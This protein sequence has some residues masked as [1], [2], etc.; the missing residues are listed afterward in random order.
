M[1][2]L[3]LLLFL[4]VVVVVVVDV[5]VKHIPLVKQ[6]LQYVVCFINGLLFFA[7]I[8]EFMC[9]NI[10]NLFMC[11]FTSCFNTV[12]SSMKHHKTSNYSS[13][14]FPKQFFHWLVWVRILNYYASYS[15]S[16]L[17]TTVDGRNPAGPAEYGKYPIIYRVLYIPGGA[18]FLFWR[19]CWELRKALQSLAPS[20]PAQ[21]TN[22]VAPDPSIATMDLCR[23][24]S[25]K[26]EVEKLSKTVPR[27][28]K[29][30]KHKG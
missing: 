7:R 29:T 30:G 25:S 19:Q 13:F 17:L 24:P 3:L 8:F 15:L 1:Q 11:K 2:K 26:P 23:L 21:A 16:L 12:A 28:R 5:L 27:F 9:W 18:G 6:D 4:V 20:I 10:Y 14:V 22:E